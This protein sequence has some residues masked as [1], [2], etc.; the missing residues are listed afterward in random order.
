MNI[1]T[2]Q[3]SRMNPS[4]ITATRV[5][6]IEA[7]MGIDRLL[8]VMHG[9]R[10]V[11]ATFAP[12]WWLC[13]KRADLFPD[14]VLFR[15]LDMSVEQ[16]Q[17]WAG[18]AS[19]DDLISE[20]SAAGKFFPAKFSKGATTAGVANNWYDLW[21][22][23]GAPAAGTYTGTAFTARQFTEATVGALYHG[24]DKTP[25][26]KH[27]I[28]MD[29]RSTGGTPTLI[30]YDRVLTYEACTFNASV[31]Q[32]L[33][34]TLP[35]QRYISAGQRGLKMMV[36]C[37]TA[38]GATA[39]NFTQI[40]YTDQDGN[41]TQSMPLTAFNAIIVSAAAPTGTLGARIVSPSVTAATLT[42]GPFMP[43]AVGD[44]GMRLVANY[45]TS[46]ANTGTMAFVLGAPLA[47]IPIQVAGVTTLIDL[48]Q[49]LVGLEQVFDGACL[50]FLA[51]FPAA[52]GT[53]FDGTVNVAWG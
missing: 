30:L 7:V 4:A 24:G 6:A 52:T 26:T 8:P 47:T 37:Q 9:R 39:A 43:L 50:S 38:L 45:T 17:K 36:T 22:V 42:Q 15:P 41:A 40:Q 46:A 48:V 21:P 12:P 29:A 53:T 14:D 20:V 11:G 49:Q 28:S 10:V 23:G 1:I 33:T 18:F 19:Y 34:N 51:F 2:T 5:A 3:K 32:A 44:G 25:D 35:A 27:T 13:Q 16:Y 31:N